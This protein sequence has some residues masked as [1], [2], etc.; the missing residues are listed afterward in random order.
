MFAPVRRR[1]MGTATDKITALS[2]RVAKK[3]FWA[4]ARARCAACDPCDIAWSATVTHAET[5]VL[6]RN[7]PTDV[8]FAGDGVGNSPG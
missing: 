4:P 6:Q 5:V 3:I 2:R 8:V 1:V 7:R